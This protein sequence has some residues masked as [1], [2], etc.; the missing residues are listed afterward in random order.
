LFCCFYV[1]NVIS[2]DNLVILMSQS[3]PWSQDPNRLPS[4]HA[5]C[6]RTSVLCTVCKEYRARFQRFYLTKKRK[7]CAVTYSCSPDG[8]KRSATG[9][10]HTC[11]PSSAGTLNVQTKYVIT[12]YGVTS[13]LRDTGRFMRGALWRTRLIP[14]AVRRHAESRERG[15]RARFYGARSSIKRF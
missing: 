9:Y 5:F 12:R 7:T 8:C 13:L 10:G 6:S 15:R 1:L 4:A 2:Q 14:M 11:H 3:L